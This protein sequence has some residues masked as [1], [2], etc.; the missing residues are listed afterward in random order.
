MKDSESEKKDEVGDGNFTVKDLERLLE[1][2]PQE[3]PRE[4][5]EKLFPPPW[6]T[7]WW[8]WI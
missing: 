6:W 1:E 7:M 2:G 5:G 8:Q 3:V 4:E